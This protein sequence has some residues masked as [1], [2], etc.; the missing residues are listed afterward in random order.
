MELKDARS[1]VAVL[2]A[3][4]PDHAMTGRAVPWQLRSSPEY[5]AIARPAYRIVAH[6]GSGHG[7]NIDDW[8]QA[9]S[10]VVHPCR[11]DLRESTEA[12]SVRAEV[13]GIL[14]AGFA[15]CGHTEK[16]GNRPA[17]SGGRLMARKATQMLEEEHHIIQGV[18]D[19]LAIL[20]EKIDKEELV[21]IE[22]LRILGQFLEVFVRHCHQ[23][24]DAH[25][26]SILEKKGA[27]AAG[28]PFA[29]LNH[30]HAIL[31]ALV[32]QYMDSVGMYIVT[33]GEAQIP[34]AKSIHGLSELLPGHIWKEDNLVLPLAEKTLAPEDQEALLLQ[35]EQVESELGPGVHHAFERLAEGLEEV[36]QPR[37][38]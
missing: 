14:S 29:V 27:L 12:I 26:F 10:E 38:G 7:R 28:C 23:R 5:E 37:R 18:A 22:A 2:V 25:L 35:F 1:F 21:P 3:V 9:E 30:E 13:P 8:L 32:S 24:K 19:A 16:G 6:R 33:R 15:H 17:R 36:F 20:G 4:Q 34:L 11:C 31:N